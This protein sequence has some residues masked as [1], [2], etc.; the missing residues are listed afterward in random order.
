MQVAASGRFEPPPNA[1]RLRREVRAFLAER[2]PRGAPERRLNSWFVT[3]PEFSR[4]LGAAGYVGMTWPGRYGGHERSQFERYIVLEELLAAGAPCGAHWIADRQTGPVILRYGTEAQ[5]DLYLPAMA[6]GELYS[7]IGLSEPGAGSDLAAVSTSA[8]KSEGGWR[9][10]GQ[11]VWT[12]NAHHATVMLA[13]VRTRPGSQRNE[14]LSQF[15]VD[16][17]TPGVTVRPI[18][19]ITGAHDFNE[20]FF[21]DAFVPADA[22]VGTEGEGWKQVTAELA[23]E[24]SGP[25]RYLSSHALLVE[26]IDSMGPAPAPAITAVVGRLTAELWPLRQMSMSTVARLAAQQDP[27]VQAAVVK[28]LGNTYEQML[29]QLVQAVLDGDRDLDDRCALTRMLALLLQIAP[30]FS[31]RGGTREILRGIIAR[32]LGLR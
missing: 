13:L 5:R 32:G 25:E 15:L 21:D 23:L 7:C 20:V 19:D 6:R 11:K 2:Q 16:L 24:R 29:P 22:L 30:S 10:N 28:D 1:A 31:L 4:A 9:V 17:A 14:G 12:S 8:R 26:L 18:I 27:M 3:D